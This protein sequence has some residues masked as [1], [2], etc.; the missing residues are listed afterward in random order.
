MFVGLNNICVGPVG[1]SEVKDL[2]GI[3]STD[4]I[5]MRG[6]YQFLIIRFIISSI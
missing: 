5:L 6:S 4:S 3:P 2:Q 1:V